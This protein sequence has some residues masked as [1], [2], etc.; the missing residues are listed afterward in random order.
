MHTNFK[1]LCHCTR[2]DMVHLHGRSQELIAEIR[3]LRKRKDELE[4]ELKQVFKFLLL[5][6]LNSMFLMDVSFLFWNVMSTKILLKYC[7]K[8]TLISGEYCKANYT[9]SIYLVFLLKERDYIFC[10]IASIFL[11]AHFPED[12]LIWSQHS[13]N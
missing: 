1:I 5:D 3:D 7:V 2:C 13:V 12:N 9:T 10:H 11:N 8:Q 4:E 6:V